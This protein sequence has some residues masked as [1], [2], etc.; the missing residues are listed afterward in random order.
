[1]SQQPVPLKNNLTGLVE[2]AILCDSID[3]AHLDLWRSQWPPTKREYE[4]DSHW[5]WDIKI[6]STRNFMDWRSFCILHKDKL[7]GLMCIRFS[8][9][10]RVPE[11][12]GLP[13]VKVE[14]LATAPWN[15]ASCIERPL[16]SG[17][18]RQLLSVAIQLS[19]DEEFQGRIALTSLPDAETFY[20]KCGMRSFPPEE[21]DYGLTYFEMTSQQS[22]V[23]LPI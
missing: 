21:V 11:T 12:R 1:M 22:E 13:L 17:V 9:E 6:E 3:K 7:Q 5:D 2:E 18:G 14:F 16:Y 10:S 23:F 8:G 4:E 15:R 19:R 20:F